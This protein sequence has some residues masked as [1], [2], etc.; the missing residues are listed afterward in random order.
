MA[1][2]AALGEE[3]APDSEITD[4][5]RVIVN[6]MPA[7]YRSTLK[8]LMEFFNEVSGFEQ[9]NKMSPY[10]ITVNLCPNIFRSSQIEND[11]ENQ[12]AYFTTMIKMIE[13]PDLIFY[14]EEEEDEEDEDSDERMSG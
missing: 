3:S 9:D 11:M 2:F 1:Q 5:I 14:D 10:N 7:L 8:F 13:Q 6:Q 12:S 4:R